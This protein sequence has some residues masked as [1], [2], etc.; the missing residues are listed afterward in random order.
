MRYLFED[1]ELDSDLFE[2]RRAGE[3]VR[4]EPQVFDVLV[5][6]VHHRDRV[7]SKEELLDEVWGDRYVS[8]SALTSRIKAARQALGDDGQLQRCIRTVHGPGVPIRGAHRRD[9]R[10]SR[11]HGGGLWGGRW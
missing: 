1:C 5:H 9:D 3:S 10:R 11:R 8:E 4:I 6:L 7:V 2:L